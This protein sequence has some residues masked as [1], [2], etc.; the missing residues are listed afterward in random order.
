MRIVVVALLLLLPVFQAE[1]AAQGSAE[2]GKTFWEGAAADAEIA[3][4]SAARAASGPIW[5]AAS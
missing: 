4:A 2:A 1:S 5:P 3:T